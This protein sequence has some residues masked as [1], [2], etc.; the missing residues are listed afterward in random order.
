MRFSTSFFVVAFAVAHASAQ[1]LGATFIAKCPDCDI[2]NRQAGL[3]VPER[4][5]EST[6]AAMENCTNCGMANFPQFGFGAVTAMIANIDSIVQQCATDGSQVRAAN[7]TPP[8]AP[9]PPAP[10]S[11]AS[12]TVAKALLPIAIV[13]IGFG[14]SI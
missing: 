7:I 4:C 13:A 6:V 14:I 11:A 8:P 1:Q 9:A 5:Q 12:K 3:A 2:F 10:K